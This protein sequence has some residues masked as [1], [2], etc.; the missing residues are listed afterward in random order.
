MA[1]AEKKM[2]FYLTILCLQKF[3]SDDAPEVP[4]GT[5]N[6]EHFMIV[7]AWKHS[8]F[9]CRNYILSGLQDDLY[10]VYSG[11]KTSK[12]LWVGGGGH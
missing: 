6:K 5:S 8:D 10:N 7:E 12:E 1:S 9:L 4:E 11:T 3:T 2:F